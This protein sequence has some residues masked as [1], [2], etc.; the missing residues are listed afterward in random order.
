ML[1]GAVSAVATQ[2][3]TERGVV[4]YAVTIRIDVPD[5]VQVPIGLSAVSTVVMHE[6]EGVLL[7]PRDAV[8]GAFGRSV[9][10][11]INNGIV[12]ERAVLLG[13]S[14][15]AWTVVREGLSEGDQVVTATQGSVTSRARFSGA[16][17]R[18]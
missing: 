7:V 10:R 2:P 17:V 16:R 1:D 15:K 11:V 18:G 14:N 4:S 8:L 6:E 3:Q 13:N 9:V 12:E 5:G